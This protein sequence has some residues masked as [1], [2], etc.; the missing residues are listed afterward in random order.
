MIQA[1]EL[2]IGNIVWGVSERMETISEIQRDRVE[3][4]FRG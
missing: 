2:R 1:N 3:T 4:V